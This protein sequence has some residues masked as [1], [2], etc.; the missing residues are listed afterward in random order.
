MKTKKLLLTFFSLVITISVSFAQSGTTGDLTWSLD[1]GT[2]TIDGVGDMPDDYTYPNLAPWSLYNES[3]TKVEIKDGV[4]SISDNAFF[5]CRNLSSIVIG[6]GVKSIG[7]Y[8]FEN[9]YELLSIIIPNSVKSIGG[10]AFRNC[11]SLTSVIIGNS[12]ESIYAEA[13]YDCRELTSITIPGSVKNIGGAAFY[14]C[15]KLETINFPNTAINLG[16][17]TF[18]ETAWLNNQPDGVIYAGKVLYTYKGAMPLNT[19]ISVDEGTL[20]ITENAFFNCT[21]LKSITIPN[22]VENIGKNVFYGC[23][24]LESV[25]IPENITEIRDMTFSFCTALQSITIPKNVTSIEEYAF[26]GCSGLKDV[27]VD[28]V[29]PP[30]CEEYAFS[31]VPV[32]TCILHIPTGSRESYNKAFLW[33]DFINMQ[34]DLSSIESSVS[35]ELVIAHFDIAGNLHISGITNSTKLILSDISGKVLLNRT[36]NP[37]ETIDLGNLPKGIYIANINGKAIKVMKN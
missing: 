29:T 7:H 37:D 35:N 32:E 21:T 1:N 9:C 24:R 11:T 17:S 28:N 31:I 13:F 12:M 23:S 27:Y 20:A 36:I 22:S 2:L 19:I 18:H 4:T 14:G 5:Y 26:Q 8:A 25:N 34:E 30:V 16:Y 15:Y 3:I 10:N 6:N 33:K